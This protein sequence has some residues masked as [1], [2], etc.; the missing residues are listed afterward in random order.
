MDQPNQLQE[1]T[2]KVEA[3]HCLIFI[4]KYKALVIKTWYWHKNRHIF[5]RNRGKSP[6]IN[7]YT[8]GQLIFDKGAENTQWRKQSFK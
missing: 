4:Y 3:L 5:Q 7:P 1:R 2:T 6:E 8:Y